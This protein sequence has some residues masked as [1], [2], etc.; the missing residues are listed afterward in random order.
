MAV[1]REE[2]KFRTGAIL[3]EVE[4]PAGG[5][6]R[7]GGAVLTETAAGFVLYQTVFGNH[8]GQAAIDDGLRRKNLPDIPQLG[9]AQLKGQADRGEPLLPQVIHGAAV[10]HVQAVIAV[11]AQ[12]GVP[13]KGQ[14]ADVSGQRGGDS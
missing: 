3:Q 13:Q 14:M 12:S 4:L 8:Q 6:L 1:G 10:E 2:R 5:L 9:E 7:N 11:Y